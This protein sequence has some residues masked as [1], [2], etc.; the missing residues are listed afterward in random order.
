M[1]EIY[2]K[3]IDSANK[4]RFYGPYDDSNYYIERRSLLDDRWNVFYYGRCVSEDASLEV[5]FN[6]I[7]EHQ[8]G[9]I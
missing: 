4:I 3:V 9:E 2:K 1:T 7:R 8:M 5:A 6:M